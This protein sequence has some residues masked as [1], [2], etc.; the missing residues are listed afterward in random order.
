ML[1][2]SYRAYL[3]EEFLWKAFHSMAMVAQIMKERKFLD[4]ETGAVP[5]LPF[6]LIHSDIKPLNSKFLCSSVSVH[7][8]VNA[9]W[10]FCS[11]FRALSLADH[12][13]LVFLGY[14]ADPKSPWHAY[15]VVKVGDWGLASLTNS[16]DP[17]NPKNFIKN[18]TP[19]YL[20]P[21]SEIPSH[22]LPSVA[23]ECVLPK[24]Q[25]DF[26]QNRCDLTINHQASH[27]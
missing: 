1:T 6:V 19:W 12:E 13:I 23:E 5:E 22:T 26:F 21:V 20:P 3:P 14:H 15:P 17:G 18:G 24:Q 10:L 7:K 25:F 8:D 2:M 27:C 11:S 4:P 16:L 9:Y